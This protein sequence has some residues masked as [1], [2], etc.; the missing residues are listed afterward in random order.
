LEIDSKYKPSNQIWSDEIGQRLI[1]R[2][3]KLCNVEESKYVKTTNKTIMDYAIEYAKEKEIDEK[4]IQL[5]NHVRLYK[6][7]IL[8]CELVGLK[9]REETKSY[10][11]ELE[12]SCLMWKVPFLILPKPSE[13]SIG[14]WLEFI[15]WLKSKEI[16]TICDFT[17]MCTSKVQISG[18]LQFLKEIMEDKV[19]YY[20]KQT[21]RYGHESCE[22]IEE[23]CR[24][25]WRLTIGTIEVNRRV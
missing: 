22:R 4:I 10:K 7:I 23:L 11:N 1:D 20:W 15:Q 12:R 16:M 21:S 8:P 3:I 24:N 14:L 5:I 13:K 2:G 25:D 19:E 17:S 6:R 18:D 9:G